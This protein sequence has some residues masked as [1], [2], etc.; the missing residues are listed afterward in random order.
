M[1]KRPLKK[2]ELTCK[3]GAKYTTYDLGVFTKSCCDECVKKY[4]L[5]EEARLQAESL[6]QQAK[7]Q[8]ERIMRAHIPPD[9]QQ[10]FFENSDPKIHPRAFEACQNYVNQFT[11]NS[12]SLLICSDVI[13]SGK[14]HLAICIANHLLQ[15]KHLNLHFIKASD[16]LLEIKSTYDRGAREGEEEVMNRVLGVSV[17]VI[18]DL[19]VPAPTE[20]TSATFWSVM[21]RRMESRLPVI[22]T[23]NYEPVD[24][25]LGRRIGTGALSRLLGMCGDN[26]VAFKGK[27]LRRNK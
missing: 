20:W 3:C 22:V 14:T 13:G 21:D 2:L 10:T 4:E 24:E 25:S 19:G 26:I 9:W 27:D 15:K 12:K 16:I 1:L 5:E 6:L 18:D 17:L 11:I 23:T 7:E 8:R